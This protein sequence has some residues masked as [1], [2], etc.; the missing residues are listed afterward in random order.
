MRR[1]SRTFPVSLAVLLITCGGAFAQFRATPPDFV[2]PM[3]GVREN[4]PVVTD[5]TG[6]AQFRL[7][8]AGDTLVYRLIVHNISNVVAAHIHL[9]PR[10]INGPVVVFL[11]GPFD[12]AGGPVEGLLASGQIESQNLVGPLAGQS[13][14]VLI[15]AMRTGGAYVNVHT[16]DGVEPTNTGPGDFPGGEI[17]GQIL[18]ARDRSPRRI[19]DPEEP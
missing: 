19:G 13:L 10:G 15:E 4:P 14:S 9:A 16:N 3:S 2:A 6:I 17:R 5:A 12:S 8:N 18:R 7:I 1:L 11:A